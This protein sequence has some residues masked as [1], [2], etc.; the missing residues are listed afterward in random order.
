MTTE[1]ETLETLIGSTSVK[2]VLG[3]IAHI[4]RIKARIIRAENGSDVLASYWDRRANVVEH[5]MYNCPI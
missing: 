2:H 3:L 1:P 4:C 5:A